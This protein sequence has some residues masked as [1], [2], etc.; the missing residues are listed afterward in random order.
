M[1][2]SQADMVIGVLSVLASQGSEGWLAAAWAMLAVLFVVNG[3]VK[4]F[5]GE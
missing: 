1:K 4:R 3:V 2:E 5:G